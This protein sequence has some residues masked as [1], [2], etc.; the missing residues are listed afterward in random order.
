MTRGFDDLALSYLCNKS[1]WF[2]QD[3]RNFELDLVRYGWFCLRQHSSEAGVGGGVA[4][5][6]TPRYLIKG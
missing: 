5:V 3:L 1:M 6:R 4:S 2:W